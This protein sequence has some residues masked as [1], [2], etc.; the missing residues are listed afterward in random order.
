MRLFVIT[1]L[2]NKSNKDIKKGFFFFYY[3]HNYFLCLYYEIEVTNII[4]KKNSYWHGYFLWLYYINKSNKD[5]KRNL[6]LFTIDTAIFNGYTLHFNRNLHDCSICMQDIMNYVSEAGFCI[7]PAG[8][9]NL[10]LSEMPLTSFPLKITW[11]TT[12]DSDRNPKNFI[13]PPCR[14]SVDMYQS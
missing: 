10:S 5:I 14:T 11:I 8:F 2:W 4:K 3:W 7:F 9:Q 6:L 13:L 12:S 1:I